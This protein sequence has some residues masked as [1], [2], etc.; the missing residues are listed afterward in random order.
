MTLQA[1]R[2]SVDACPRWTKHCTWLATASPFGTYWACRSWHPTLSAGQAETAVGGEQAEMVQAV[3]ERGL[4]GRRFCLTALAQLCRMPCSIDMTVRSHCHV[5]CAVAV[6]CLHVS[7]SMQCATAC[8]SKN[9]FVYDLPRC[10]GVSAA[11]THAWLILFVQRLQT[12]SKG[13]MNLC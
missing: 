11:G 1:V 3:W 7:L 5:Y 4:A 10:C 6:P 2:L 9:M 12:S 13:A 8:S